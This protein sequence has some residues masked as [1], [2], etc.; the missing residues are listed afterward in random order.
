MGLMKNLL[1]GARSVLGLLPPPRAYRVPG[2]GFRDDAAALRG[3]F[4]RVGDALRGPI[5]AAR[6]IYGRG[7]RE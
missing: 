7:R 4:R 1:A 6:Q 2:K 3:D 5:K